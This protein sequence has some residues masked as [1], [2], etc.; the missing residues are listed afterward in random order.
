MREELEVHVDAS[1]FTREGGAYG[2]L[3]GNLKL[4]F[5][6]QIGDTISFG[7]TERSGP[8]PPGFFGQLRVTDRILSAGEMT[9]TL[10]VA[11]EDIKVDTVAVAGTLNAFFENGFGLFVHVY[12][13]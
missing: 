6:P 3:S 7:P 10:L 9:D 2:M 1:I 4:S 5:E 12:D 13:S 11:L 8:C